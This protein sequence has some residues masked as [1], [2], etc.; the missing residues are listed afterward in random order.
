MREEKMNKTKLAEVII[1]LSLILSLFLQN[2]TFAETI[3]LK[4]GKTI[5]GKIIERTDEDITIDFYGVP[6]PYFLDQIE[7]VDG[8]KLSTAPEAGKDSVK[9]H[10]QEGIQY[11]L[12]GQFNNAEGSFKMVLE[13]NSSDPSARIFLDMLTDLNK[14]IIDKEY[15]FSLARGIDCLLNKMN[16]SVE[17]IIE[18]KK[19]IEINPTYAIAYYILGR[20][21]LEQQEYQQA[22][23]Y[24]Q[25]FTQ[26][27]TQRPDVYILIGRAY[28]ELGQYSQVKES[29][30]KAIELF[31]DMGDDQAA[32]GVE[33]NLANILK[34]L[35]APAKTSTT[36]P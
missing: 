27:K 4:S 21:Y 10:N 19:A 33:E 18:L 25:K 35:E 3:V 36:P 7:S 11:I 12:D 20:A 32:K 29:F 26:L 24:F 22:I 8:Q 1:S 15:L 2:N 17:T 5:E 6:V 31:Q 34:K 23:N 30:Q 9:Q 28:Y 14:G 16:K 13:K